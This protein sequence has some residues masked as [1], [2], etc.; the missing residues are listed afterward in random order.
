M[1]INV[2]WCSFEV[3]VRLVRFQSN[4]NFFDRFSKSDRITNVMKILPLIGE[5]FHADGQ[6][7]GRTDRTKLIVALHN[8]AYAPNEGISR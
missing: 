3:P 1:S 7:D 2:Y 8:F 6:A 4:L 5:M